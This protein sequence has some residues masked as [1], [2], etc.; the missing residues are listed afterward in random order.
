MKKAFWSLLAASAVVFFACPARAAGNTLLALNT[1]AAPAVQVLTSELQAQAT[2]Q[3]KA[4]VDAQNDFDALS[5]VND[6]LYREGSKEFLQQVSKEDAVKNE[7]AAAP[8]PALRDAPNSVPAAVKPAPV[9]A[10]PPAVI[11]KP[12]AK[13]PPPLDPVKGSNT[14]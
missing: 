9:K 12:K 3:L 4:D 13:Q 14:L 8:A 1:K 5:E 2:A 11:S 7:G 10:V 6:P